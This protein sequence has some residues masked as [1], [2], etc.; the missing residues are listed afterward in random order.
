MKIIEC[1]PFFKETM[2]AKVHVQESSRWVDEFHI[3]EANRSFQNTPKEYCFDSRLTSQYPKV[4]YHPVDVSRLFKPKRQYVPNIALNLLRS[5]RW[6]F[7]NSA[8]YND[9]V[10]RNL[11]RTFLDFRD[12][13]ILVFSD[14]DEIIDSR[15]ADQLISEVKKRDIITVRLHHTFFYFNLFCKRMDSHVVPDWSYRVV[16]L[17]GRVFRRVWKSDTDWLRKQSERGHLIGQV[18]CPEGYHGFHHT[19]LGDKNCVSQKLAAY[20][21]TELSHLN[22]REYIETC[23]REK[24]SIY[25]QSLDIDNGIPLL[26][27]VEALRS[28]LP[29]LFT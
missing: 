16:L 14:S 29:D 27:S 10:Q 5:G 18:F 15:I 8:W 24:R 21:H 28:E 13:D 6:F 4:H 11:S 25:G 2:L 17:K 26:S 7:F 1:S 23:I 19:F 3:V 9:G 12:D 22:T 20:A